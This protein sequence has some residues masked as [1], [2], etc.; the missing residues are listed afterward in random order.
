MIRPATIED[1]RAVAE[2]GERFHAE[3]LWSTV[4]DYV[5]GDCEA[6]LR[7][8]IEQGI[9]LVADEGQI[10]GMAGG[11]IFPFYFNHSHLT[12]NE[13]FLW[14]TPERRGSLGVRLLDAME[15]EAVRRGCKSWGMNLM[16]SIAPERTEKLFLRRGYRP[17][18]R[19]F[20]KVF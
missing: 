7:Q 16:E 6:S 4:V 1:C 12:G 5:A 8:L 14:V 15:T 2:L 18:E 3:A 9:L 17:I 10:V 20:V 11:M 19:T 13:L